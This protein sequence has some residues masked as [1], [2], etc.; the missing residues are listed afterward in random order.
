LNLQPY[1]H[2]ARVVART[3]T[4]ADRPQVAH[5]VV[6]RRCNLSCGYCNEYDRVS[7]PVPLEDLLE[8][9]SHLHRLKTSVIACSGGE[10]LLHPHIDRLIRAIRQRGIITTLNTNGYPLTRKRI[11]LLNAAG[12][13]ALQISID[14]LEPDE[15]SSKSLSVLGRRLTLLA[16]TA[17]FHVNV[18][19]VLGAGARPSDAVDIARRAVAC[20]FS[21]SVGLVH[22]PGGSLRPLS[23]DARSA[24]RRIAFRS[25]PN[26]TNYWLFQRSLLRGRPRR[27]KCRAGARFLYVD[28][29]GLVFWCSQRRD[30]P[31]V[32]L[33]SYGREDIRRAFR[34]RK[35]CAPYCT[36]N[37][38]HQ[39]SALDGWRRQ[40]VQESAVD[41]PRTG[42][43]R[44]VLRG[45]SR[46]TA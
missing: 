6:T 32:P 20:G 1:F 41:V 8:R 14:N 19:T 3:L 34:T 24:Y 30:R 12:L 45:D 33:R 13:H 2:L 29:R 17:R 35:D 11:E 7:A 26:R 5:L 4:C 28:E 22:A 18:N 37:C 39:A 31:G 27:W 43:A 40:T 44:T 42:S 25:L 23:Q 46:S 15:V 21:H 38:V 9:V 36:L 10:P 16:N